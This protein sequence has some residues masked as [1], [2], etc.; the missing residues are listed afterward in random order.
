MAVSKTLAVLVILSTCPYLIQLCYASTL[1]YNFSDP[2]SFSY[3]D[4]YF[5]GDAYPG[6]TS[7]VMA[8]KY[9]G[10]VNSKA[11]RVLYKHPV[12][13]WSN[14]TGEVTSFTTT[15]SFVMNGGEGGLEFFLTSY[16]SSLLLNSSAGGAGANSPASDHRVVAVE[17]DTHG[18]LGWNPTM[19]PHIGADLNINFLEK[20]SYK[21]IAGDLVDGEPKIVRIDYSNT[22]NVLVVALGDF[23]TGT[24]SLTLNTSVDLRRSLPQQ[25]TI[26]FSANTAKDSSQLVVREV[27]WWSFSTHLTEANQPKLIP[28]RDALEEPSNSSTSP[29]SGP[30]AHRA[31]KSNRSLVVGIVV[32]TVLFAV[33]ALVLAFLCCLSRRVR[34]RQ[35]AAPPYL[36]YM[37]SPDSLHSRARRFPFEVLSEAT[38]NFSEDRLLGEEGNF[39]KFYRGDLTDFGAIPVAAVKWLKIKS[40]PGFVEGNYMDDLA[41]ISRERHRNIVQF[42]GWSTE[43]DN[44]CL[45]YEFVQNGSLHDHL[46]NSGRLLTW[47]MRYNIILCIG[48]GLEYLHEH[49]RHLTFIHRN[50]KPTNV[51][52][53]EEMNAKLGDFGLPQHFLIQDN[54]S[55]PASSSRRKVLAASQAYVD[56]EI[57][58]V[59]EATTSS[60]VYSFGTVCGQPPVVNEDQAEANSLVH[61][62]AN[63]LVDFVWE[64]QEKGSIFEACD[65]RLNG[66]FNREEMERV[67][68]V[69]LC[70]AHPYSSQRPS[71]SEAMSSL[72]LESPAP[73][74]PPR[75]PIRLLTTADEGCTSP[76]GRTSP[77]AS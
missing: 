12:H 15:F 14:T 50:I 77:S 2:A 29:V 63:S 6:D 7:V 64:S 56:P 28:A 43:Q 49:V 39:G 41:T 38:N 27:L 10:D 34:R 32:G 55:E 52:L 30:P 61:F 35:Q 57:L 4:L 54:G 22:T 21:V 36:D 62:A 72:K 40:E 76:I 60:D 74:L 42:L 73:S 13:L 19:S 59:G 67:L 16:P 51:M 45:V 65:K 33:I 11:G 23:K 9:N 53:D 18:D 68:L 5:E 37:P 58:L 48:S 8:K 1:S 24:S 66:D 44:L 17:F 3:G 26:G 46:Y 47:P 20:N 31:K 75:M 70:C 25:V 71:I 69:G